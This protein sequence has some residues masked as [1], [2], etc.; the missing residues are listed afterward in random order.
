MVALCLLQV[1]LPR[2]NFSGYFRVIEVYAAKVSGKLDYR[3][4]NIDDGIDT[5]CIVFTFDIMV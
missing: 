1:Q 2:F 4:M 5:S 3:Q